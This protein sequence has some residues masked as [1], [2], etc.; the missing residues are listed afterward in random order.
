VEHVW[1]DYPRSK[2]RPPLRPHIDNHR[3]QNQSRPKDPAR[4]PRGISSHQI[5]PA[6]G[7]LLRLLINI[8]PAGRTFHRIHRFIPLIRIHIRFIRLFGI[9]FV[10]IGGVVASHGR[11]VSR[12][13]CPCKKGMN[14][15]IHNN[16]AISVPQIS[17]PRT[18]PPS[19][20]LLSAPPRNRRSSRAHLSAAPSWDIRSLRWLH[21]RP[22]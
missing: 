11:T 9:I 5:R 2:P 7:A 21:H 6:I 13:S 17:P 15:R 19:P 22:G 16:H 4:M 1:T 3:E 14:S 20:L 10:I 18:R 8:P 12:A